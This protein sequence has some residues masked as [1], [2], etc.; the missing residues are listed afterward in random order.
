MLLYNGALLSDSDFALSLP[1]RGLYFN[2]GFFETMVWAEGSVRYLPH[3]WQRL[4]RAA[5]VL[6]YVLPPD[7]ASPQA[8][9]NALAG[10][11]TQHP[12][13]QQAP[14]RVRLQL[15]RDGGGL[16]LPTTTHPNWLATLQPFVA[17]A[18]PVTTADFARSVQVHASPVSFCKGPNAL[19]YV[20]A[21]QER[22]QRNLDELVLL[23]SA[24]HVAEAVAAAIAWIREG[25]VYCPTEA[26]GCVAGT[27]LAHLREKA[28]QLG[29]EWQEG[30]FSPSELVAAEAV[31]TANVAGIRP[32]QQVAAV[33]INSVAHPLLQALCAADTRHD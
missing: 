7:L 10:L 28:H 25:T 12:E 2:D 20:L 15:W 31:F 13:Y 26:T 23:S 19:L 3:H 11:V 24:G 21:A 4:K 27:R 9:I 14:A 29:I 8:L 1:N 18:A 16:Y 32:I 6:G 17:H 22:A 33:A 5:T 30:L